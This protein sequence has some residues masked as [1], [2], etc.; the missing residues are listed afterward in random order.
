MV[1]YSLIGTRPRNTRLSVPRLIALTCARIKTS[2]SPGAGKA[3]LRISP[4]PGSASQKAR[5]CRV[6]SEAENTLKERIGAERQT[7]DGRPKTKARLGDRRQ[8]QA[9]LARTQEQRRDRDLQPVET[10]GAQEIGN[11]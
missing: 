6:I 9:R 7:A 8:G 2:L 11:R 4:R 10:T 3:A 5:A 1:R